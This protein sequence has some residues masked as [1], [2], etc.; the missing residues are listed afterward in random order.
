MSFLRNITSGLRALVRKKRA[1]AELDEELRGYL[2]MAAKEKM[3]R[4]MS[5]KESLRAVRLEQGSAEA[6]REEV[7]AAGWESFVET[8]WQDIRFG[9]RTLKKSPGFTA[10]AVLTLAL[11][12]GANTAIFSYVDAWLIKPLPY[13]EPERLMVFESH[14]RKNGWTAANI[15]STASFLDYQKQ[16]TSFEQTAGWASWAFNLTGDGEPAL[17]DGARVSWNFFDALGAKPLLGK[18]FTPDEDQ[19]GTDHVAI[20]AEGLWQSRYGGDPN[21]IGRTITIEGEP[22]AVVGVMPGKFQFTLRGLCNLWTP[23]ALTDEQRTDRGSSFFSAFGRLKA[24]VTREQAEAESKTI[25]AT[26][27]KQ[28]PQTN[29]NLTQL[30]AS[31]KEEIARNEGARQVLMCLAIVGLVLLIACANV[32]NLMLGRATNRA[33]EFGVRGA[34]GATRVRLVR[35]LLTESLLLFLLGGCAGAL[36]GV[37]GVR[38]IEAQIPAHI[39]GYLVNYGHVNLSI[40]TLAFTL[41]IVVVCGI[42]FGLVPAFANSRLDVNRTLKEAAG[43]ASG[44]Q[45]GAALRR[46]LVAAEISLAVV[47]L[48]STTLLVRSFVISVRSSPGYNAANVMI[49]QV[50]LPKTKYREEARQR[51]FSEEVLGRLRALPQLEAAGAA[52]SVPYGG[53]GAW[54]E[55]EAVGKPVPPPGERQGAS[56]TAVSDDYFATMQI[57]LLK[58]RVF[59]SVDAPGNASAAIINQTMARALWPDEDPIGRPLRFG[60]QHAACTVVGVVRDIKMYYARERPRPE[61]YVSLAQ[62]PSTTLGFVARIRGENATTAT[63]VRDAIWAVDRNQPVSSVEQLENIMGIV[64]S[65]DRTITRLMVFFGATAMFLAMLGIYGVMSNL[66]AQRTHELGIRAALGASPRQMMGMVMGQG[67][68]LALAGIGIGLCCALLAGRALEGM[69]YQVSPSDPATFATV[70]VLFAAVAL[71]A[72]WMPARRAMAVNPVVALRCE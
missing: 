52:S 58:G 46:T 29:T 2:E 38:W 72:C 17:V 45:R 66:V 37:F 18:T 26:L 12:I 28:F 7:A 42:A 51:N 59:G 10:V 43:Q 16:N 3:K 13:P 8:C 30:V 15:T 60:E 19:A 35:Q 6:S 61:M 32:A 71:A 62:F 54:V 1:D 44:A 34:L 36:F 49:A 24:G 47:V 56:Y 31:M 5:R 57:P 50:A 4:G 41:G 21:V 70:P 20:L 39:R 67:L 55:A 25:F 9:A 53:F 22:Y 33:T 11:G 68:Y 27:E 69:L 65:G 23:L 40:T 14:D 63:A 48:I 64:N